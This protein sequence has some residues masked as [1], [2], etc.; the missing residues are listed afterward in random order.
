MIFN[1]QYRNLFEQAEL[2]DCYS[3]AL[4]SPQHYVPFAYLS[5]KFQ[6]L[7]FPAPS[8]THQGLRIIGILL[9]TLDI[10]GF[11]IVILWTMIII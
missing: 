8:L 7:T 2:H 4:V 11:S 1:I 6:Y 5:E 10:K 9:C 3:D